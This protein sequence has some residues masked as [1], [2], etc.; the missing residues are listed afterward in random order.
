[1]SDLTCSRCDSH[2]GHIFEDAPQTLTGQRFCINSVA[3]NFIPAGRGLRA[4]TAPN[5]I[6]VVWWGLSTLQGFRGV[7][8]KP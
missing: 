4:T 6:V 2:L 1:M 8:D 3:L 7:G 5:G